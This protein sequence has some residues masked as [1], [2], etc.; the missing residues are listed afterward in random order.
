MSENKTHLIAKNN[1]VVP[2]PL[3]GRRSRGRQCCRAA[4]SEGNRR[5]HVEQ[6]IAT[7]NRL[8]ARLGL[9]LRLFELL[10]VSRDGL[11]ESGHAISANWDKVVMQRAKFR[12]LPAASSPL[13]ALS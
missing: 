10:V 7:Q 13:R 6:R 5:L 1:I 2:P 8:A 9:A 3:D 4:A 11:V 12:Q